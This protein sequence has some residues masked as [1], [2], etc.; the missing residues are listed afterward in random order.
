MHALGGKLSNAWG[1]ND[2]PG[3]VANWVLNWH[4]F[5]REGMQTDLTGP[6]TGSV[7]IRRGHFGLRYYFRGECR[8]VDFRG[9]PR[10]SSRLQARLLLETRSESESAGDLPAEA[11]GACA[12]TILAGVLAPPQW[13]QREKGTGFRVVKVVDSRSGSDSQ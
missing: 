6:E 7:A 12:E 11:L 13:D 8:R 10:D 3:N 2:A 4:D 5:Y 9:V 1:P